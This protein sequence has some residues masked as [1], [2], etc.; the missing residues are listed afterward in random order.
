[1][2]NYQIRTAGSISKEIRG[3]NAKNWVDLQILLYCAGLRVVFGKPRDSLTKMPGR[4]GT[5]G[6]H[7]LDHDPAAQI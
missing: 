7:L 1:M 4:T 5:R 3:L 6:F 2:Q